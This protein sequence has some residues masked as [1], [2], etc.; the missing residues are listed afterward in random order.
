MGAALGSGAG[1]G[2][3][4]RSYVA[5]ADGL[6]SFDTADTSEFGVPTTSL[7]PKYSWLGAGEIPTELPSGVMDMGARSY[8]PQLGRFLQ[9]DPRP[10]G[11]ANAYTYTF[12]DPVNTF[13]SFGEFTVATPT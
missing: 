5:S 8:V 7:P 9:P 13:D 1:A 4:G 11:S 12:G 10:G 3:T 6:R 2:S